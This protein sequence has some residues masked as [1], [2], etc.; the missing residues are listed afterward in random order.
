MQDDFFARLIGEAFV[1]IAAAAATLVGATGL[2][3]SVAYNA[4]GHY[5]VF[6]RAPGI[7]MGQQDA[8]TPFPI[9]TAYVQL[10]HSDPALAAADVSIVS[11]TQIDVYVT[12]L[13]GVAVDRSFC[14]MVRNTARRLV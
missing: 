5:T 13:A 14:L 7:R 11:D 3:D 1:G 10:I 9:P 6:L 12:D 2:V 4:A 8:T